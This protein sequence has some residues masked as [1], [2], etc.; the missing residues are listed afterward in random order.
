MF[1][2]LEFD[3]IPNSALIK[4]EFVWSVSVFVLSLLGYI[5]T[6]SQSGGIDGGWGW[7]WGCL[8]GM[9]GSSFIIFGIHLILESRKRSK[10]G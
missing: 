3:Q 4:F 8:T 5:S 10:K 1:D 7:F 6:F 9:T 2:W